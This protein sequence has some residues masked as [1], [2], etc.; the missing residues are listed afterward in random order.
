VQSKCER[1][2]NYVAVRIRTT[3]ERFVDMFEARAHRH[4]M[5]WQQGKLG[6]AAGKPLKCGKP[7]GSGKRADRIHS[8]VQIERGEPGPRIADFRDPEA[9][10][11]SHESKRVT[12]HSL[13]TVERRFSQE[14]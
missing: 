11:G 13:S 10:L 2:E 6:R 1:C 4:P 3:F 9:D 7:M 8:F 14:G 12:S 5:P